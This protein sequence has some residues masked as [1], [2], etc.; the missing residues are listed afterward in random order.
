MSPWWK[1]QRNVDWLI[2]AGLFIAGFVALWAT[3]ASVGF[4][5]DESVY[6]AAARY[7][8]IWLMQLVRD[9]S[10]A[11]SDAAIVRAFDLNH[12][13]PALMKLL[14]GIS[15]QVFYE[16]LHWLRPATPISNR[17]VESRLFSLPPTVSKNVFRS[18]T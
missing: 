8:A 2:L 5:R 4:V 11:L 14:F 9:P 16:K 10:T 18:C 13:H 17:C 1:V 7:Y 3:E 6:F 12:E 15:H